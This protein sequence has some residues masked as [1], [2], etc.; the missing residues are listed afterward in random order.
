MKRDP[1]STMKPVVAGVSMLLAAFATTQAVAADHALIMG[2][3]NYANSRANLPGIDKDVA[4]AR[5]IAQS[6][7]VPAANIREINDAQVTSSGVRQAMDQLESTIR[8][9]DRVFI[10]Y[11]GHG[12]QE[13]N[14]SGGSRCTEGMFVHDMSLY[15]DSDLEQSLQKI[16]RKA[17][18]LVMFNDSCFSGG[19][20]TKAIG[21][22]NAVPKIYKAV[23]QQTNYT[24]GDAINTKS[25]MRNLIATSAKAGNNMVYIA[26]A[27]D[28]EVAFAT[29][30]GSSATLAWEACLR[31][32]EADANRSGGLTAEELR[33]CAQ[34]GVK[35][36]GFNQTITIEGN[37]NLPV[38]FAASNPRPESGASAARRSAGTLEDI[39]QGASSAIQ[40]ELRAAKQELTINRDMLDFSVRTNRAGYLYVLHVGSDGK[41]FDLLFPNDKDSNNFV[42]PGTVNMPRPN[43]AVMAG[44]PV[45]ESYLMAIVSEAP[46]DYSAMMRE[47]MGPFRAAEADPEG[48][49]NL[50]TVS[51]NAGR[52]GSG[53]YGAS[54]VVG[55]RERN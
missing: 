14:S 17:S 32:P 28:D 20:A 53:Q 34:A 50:F 15:K 6:M 54:A 41:T 46:R 8:Q 25:A 55:I 5:R 23:A 22:A 3:G 2:V 36:M 26:A 31:S 40:V 45:G 44:G 4:I 21:P 18:Q 12:A 49:K 30:D 19:A 37:R 43:W 35:K 10:Y 9:G 13:P 16:S 48:Q 1:F 38:S 39:R 29:R 27:A 33:Q 7:G 52:P 24:C 11:S 47:K 42:Q 51:T